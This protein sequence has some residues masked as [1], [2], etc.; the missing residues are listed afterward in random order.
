MKSDGLILVDIKGVKELF[1]VFPLG[2]YDLASEGVPNNRDL[3]E[4]LK[5][6]FELYIAFVL[7]EDSPA[8]P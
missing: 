8:E 4:K 1:Y 6:L 7:S 5:E 3:L 2:G